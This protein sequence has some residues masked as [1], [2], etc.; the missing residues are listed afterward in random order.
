MGSA[1]GKRLT[2]KSGQAV[3]TPLSDRERIL[4]TIISQ[5]ATTQTLRGPRNSWSSEHYRDSDDRHFV[6]FAAWKTPKAGDLVLA[7]TGHVSPWKVGFYVEPLPGSFGGAVIREIGSN[8]LC[9][10]AN[11]SFEPIVGLHEIELLEGDR[12][13]FYVKVMKA[14]RRG[15]EY[16][17]RFGG[18]KFTG[19]E[20][21][22]GVR[23]AHG[24]LRNESVPFEVRIH[25]N[26]RM[27][28]S[29]ILE[30]MRAQGYGTKSFRPT[31][32]VA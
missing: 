27:A 22:I 8:K 24:G 11:E 12:R 9:N 6:H 23:E 28:V 10:Y 5:L 25:W 20:A 31:Q 32:A 15:D 3:E 7:K 1:R 14:F 2:K 29:K 26:K 4:M 13:A 21:V 19:D 30:A 17:Y 16:L 18:L